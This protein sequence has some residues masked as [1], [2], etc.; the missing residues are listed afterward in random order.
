MYKNKAFLTMISIMVGITFLGGCVSAESTGSGVQISFAETVGMGQEIRLPE[1]ILEKMEEINSDKALMSKYKNISSTTY[2]YYSDHEESLSSYLDTDMYRSTEKNKETIVVFDYKAGYFWDEDNN[3]LEYIYYLGDSI[4]EFLSGSRIAEYKYLDKE[5]VIRVEETSQGYSITTEIDDENMVLD[6]AAHF[7]YDLD[8]L[9]RIRYVY[10]V[11]K[12]Y[13]LQNYS[14]FITGDKD[15]RLLE[16]KIS[17]DGPAQSYDAEFKKY[18]QNGTTYTFVTDAD[19]ENEKEEKLT[20][21][22]NVPFSVIFPAAYEKTAYF[23]ETCKI[24][25]YELDGSCTRVYI[26]L[27]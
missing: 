2:Y 10:F 17:Y 3:N 4:D 16:H 26:E 5:R 11:N 21:T 8:G 12:A 23:D 6:L 19:T 1:D 20:V 15:I 24:P 9:K 18:Y 22:D 27:R 7:Q 25:M 13:E 14:Q